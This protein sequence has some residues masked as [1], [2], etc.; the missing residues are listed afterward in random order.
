MYR[1]ALEDVLG[2]RLED[3]VMLRVKPCIPDEWPGYSLTWT[4][5][6]PSATTMDIQVRNP[7]PRPVVTRATLDGA[8][9]TVRDGE[10]RIPPADGRAI[11]S[12][13]SSAG[14]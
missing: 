9:G 10:A 1:V 3:G 4:L 2:V 11:G 7:R 13:S 8:P 14:R 12:R 5:P 6:G